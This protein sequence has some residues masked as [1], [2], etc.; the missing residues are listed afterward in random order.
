[1]TRSQIYTETEEQIF[2]AALKVFSMKGRDGA[3]M[4]EIA[5]EAGI[6]QALLHYYFRS[7]EKLYATVFAHVFEEFTSAARTP[8]EQDLPFDQFFETFIDRLVS[9]HAAHPEISRLWVLENLAGAP[10]IAQ[11]M[12]EQM[13][14]N[15]NLVPKLFIARIQK[16]IDDGEV[17]AVDPFQTF[18]TLLGASVFFFLAFPTLSAVN[19]S[20]A[21]DRDSAIDERKKHLFDILYH[22][23]EKK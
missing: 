8:F 18:V 20:L 6:N 22:G 19:P 17:R 2:D 12:K 14:T 10:V 1:M 4:Q 5:E 23:L 3:R 15:P 9:I 11:M 21:R 13:E 7:K 16:A